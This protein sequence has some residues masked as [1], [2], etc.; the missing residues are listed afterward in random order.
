[1]DLTS[2]Y[3]FWRVRN[4]LRAN[5]PALDRDVVCDVVV[6]GGGITGALVGF[7]LAQ[8][9]VV[10]TL[11]DK[12][13]I[14]TGSTSGSTAL[15]QYEV[16]VPLRQ[17]IRQIGPA[18][19]NR[20]Y[21]LCWDAL[22]KIDSLVKKLKLRCEFEKRPS[23]FLAR[24]A[25]EIPELRKELQLRRKLGIP[26]DF[27]DESKIKK[28]FPFSRPAA[29]FSEDG[30]QVDPHRLTH[31]LLAAACERG[32]QVFDRTGI[33]HFKSHPRSVELTTGDGCKIKARR[34]VVAAGF[35]SKNY[36]RG[37]G[38]GKLKSTYALISEPVD[39]LAGWYRRSLI[40]E[41][42]S[43]Y[44]YLR[45]TPENRIIVGG[46]DEDF[47]NPKKR[48]ALIPQKTRTLVRKFKKLFPG[49]KME[50]AYAWAGTFGETRD[51]L[52]RIGKPARWPHAYFALGYGGN[53]ITYSVIAAELI[54]D[55]F[56]GR[57]NPDAAIFAFGRR[58]I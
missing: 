18:R 6:I 13:D 33:I 42:G 55:D 51:G 12:R 47:V 41:S 27:W 23:L 53:G 32:L 29:L 58:V 7:H 50:V 35:E 57:K 45:T 20:S 5:Y 52:A 25:R 43:P 3:P 31:G 14:G 11:V 17:L 39:D 19:A 40:W 36:L 21:Q 22:G 44:L 4:G 28:H 15:L 8:A 16:D 9:G 56:L 24:S 26:L 2:D 34:L 38:A 37:G 48:D 10:T 1:M 49:Q 46:E 30:A 54:R